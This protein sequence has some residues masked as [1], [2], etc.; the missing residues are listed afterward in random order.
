M[1]R[2]CTPASGDGNGPPGTHVSTLRVTPPSS[3]GRR[4]EFHVDGEPGL[5]HGRSRCVMLPSALKVHESGFAT[6]GSVV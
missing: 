4:L 2:F 6:S 1:A 5:A 3:N